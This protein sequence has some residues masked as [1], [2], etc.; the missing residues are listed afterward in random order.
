MPFRFTEKEQQEIKDIVSR[1]PQQISAT[2][3]LLHLAQKRTGWVSSDVENEVARILD[4]PQLH[5]HDVV[6]FYT[7]FQ[8]KP[9]GKFLISVCRTLSC[10]LMGAPEI[11]AYLSERLKLDGKCKG[12]DPNS[13]FTLEE[14]ECLGACGS[15]PVLLVNG[16]YHENM[17]VDKVKALLD[18]LENE[19]D[20]P[21]SLS[22]GE[23]AKQES[24]GANV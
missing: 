21:Q 3:P 8:R 22:S 20:I 9:I 10:H 18:S 19:K 15:A 13:M 5:V 1:Y 16:V 12:T 11:S 2:L 6:S 23:N 14:V 4:I 24:E 7:M 17:T